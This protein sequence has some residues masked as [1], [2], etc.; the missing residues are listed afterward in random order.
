MQRDI[1]ISPREEIDLGEI[2]KGVELLMR[3][4]NPPDE[5][6]IW[7]KKM[8]AALIT[9]GVCTGILTLMVGGI[10]GYI[11]R[12][13]IQDN[14]QNAYTYHPEMFDENGQLV[15]DEIISFRIEGDESTELE[16]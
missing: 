13:Y 2:N 12:T 11:L 7:R 15:P 8:E 9:I 5:N 10:L 4:T 16:D 1:E 3:G 14:N 6:L